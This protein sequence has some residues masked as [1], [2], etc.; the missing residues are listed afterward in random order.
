MA[1]SAKYFDFPFSTDKFEVFLSQTAGRFT[2]PQCVKVLLNR[3]GELIDETK[4]LYSQENRY[5]VC[6]A[7]HPIDSRN[8]FLFHKTTRREIYPSFRDQDV[9]PGGEGIDDLLLFNERDELTEFTIGNLVVEM[10][11]EFYTPPL[12]C[13]LLAGTFRAHLLEINKIKERVIHKDEL[14]KCSKVFLVNSVRQWVD[15]ILMPCAGFVL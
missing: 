1:D 14:Q 11:G 3:F 10:D 4:D 13:G 15:V 6:L 9:I 8:V 12:A 7:T 5:K 2:S